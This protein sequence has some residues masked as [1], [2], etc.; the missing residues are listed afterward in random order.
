MDTISPYARKCTCSP[1]HHHEDTASQKYSKSERKDADD[2][3]WT[4]TLLEMD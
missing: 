1:C 4:A 2:Y 3:G